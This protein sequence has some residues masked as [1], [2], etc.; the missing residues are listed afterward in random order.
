MST[1]SSLGRHGPVPGE[2]NAVEW[3]TRCDLAACYRLVDHY[4]WSD[5]FG[6]HISLRV[7]GTEHFLLNPYGMLFGEITA[8]SLIKGNYSP[9]CAAG[10]SLNHWVY[11][12]QRS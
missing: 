1:P 3:E 8:S 5:L 12:S 10:R 9:P 7:P 4:G 11:E 6:T 2:S